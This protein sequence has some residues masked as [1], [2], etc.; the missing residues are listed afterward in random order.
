[1]GKVLVFSDIHLHVWKNYSKIL[2]NGLNS[3]LVDGINVIKQIENYICNNS[4]DL[5][6]FT[7]DFFH[8]KRQIYVQ[9]FNAAY[10]AISSLADTGVPIV[11]IVGNHDQAD[12]S[13]ASH[14]LLAF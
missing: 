4:I 13:G 8:V 3:R 1:M 5:V 9:A 2:D 6:L 11:A 10:L 7:G 12:K 14:S